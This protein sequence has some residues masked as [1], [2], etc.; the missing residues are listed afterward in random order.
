M[1]TIKGVVEKKYVNTTKVGLT[2]ALVVDNVRYGFYKT[3]PKCNEGDSVEFEASQK[4]DFWNADGKT[5]KVLGATR[6]ATP[7]AATKSWV[8]DTARQDSITFQSAR[9][10]ALSFM[11]LLIKSGNLDT[12]KAKAAA[13]K[14]DVMLAYLD[15]LTERFF[16]DT[17]HLGHQEDP[18]VVD[19]KDDGGDEIPF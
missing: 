9:K 15:Q 12:G 5:L 8:P 17:K 10:D 16:E 18:A 11:D 6:V 19:G 2:Y 13:S 1:T 14:T 3:D 4:G 7:A